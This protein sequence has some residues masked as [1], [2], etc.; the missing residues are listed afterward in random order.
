MQNNMLSGAFAFGIV[1]SSAFSHVECQELRDPEQ[2]VQTQRLLRE[3]CLCI[4]NSADSGSSTQSGSYGQNCTGAQLTPNPPIPLLLDSSS[5]SNVTVSVPFSPA[6]GQNAFANGTAF[7][8]TCF[9]PLGT[10]QMAWPYGGGQMDSASPSTTSS[11][12]SSGTSGSATASSSGAAT[13][14]PNASGKTGS[15]GRRVHMGPSGSL[16]GTALLMIAAISGWTI[17][18]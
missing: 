1:H 6:P 11:T 18:L 3:S 4:F 5:T 15:A 8:L 7:G 12:S 17:V 16:I 14:S 2:L 13:A 9:L 10:D